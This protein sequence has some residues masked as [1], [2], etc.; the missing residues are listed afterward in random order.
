METE[1]IMARLLAEISTGQEHMKDLLA[2]MEAK[3]DGRQEKMK[4]Q[5]GSLASRIDANREEM[6]AKMDATEEKMDAWIAEMK[7]GQKK[8]MMAC[9]ETTE[10]HLDSKE[11]NPEEIQ[12]EAVH[13]EGPR[14]GAVAKS[15]GALRKR[16]E[17][18]KLAEGTAPGKLRIPEEIGRCPQRDD[19]PCRSGT[20]QGTRRQEES[21]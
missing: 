1:Q 9:Q 12:S 13:R 15:S 8:E 3:T 18:R 16:H 5:L 20:A 17:G 4:A 10:A 6:N 11:P 2:R 7:D 19:P 21:D 14:E